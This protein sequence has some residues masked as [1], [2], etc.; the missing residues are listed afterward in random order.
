[1]RRTY[2]RLRNWLRGKK[3][4]SMTEY[5]MTLSLIVAGVV[6]VGASLSSQIGALVT[7]LLGTILHNVAR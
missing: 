2:T 5:A 3:G 7:R 1:M 6:V 4:Q